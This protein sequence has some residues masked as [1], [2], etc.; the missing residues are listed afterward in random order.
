M[1]SDA[2]HNPVLHG[3]YKRREIA[4]AGGGKLVL[5]VNG[6]IEQIEADGTTAGTWRPEDDEW[7][8]HAIRFGLQPRPDTVP[9]ASRRQ[10]EPFIR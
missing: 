9:P 2:D 7:A 4:L 3:R 8:T 10:R 5:Q 6:S 1:A